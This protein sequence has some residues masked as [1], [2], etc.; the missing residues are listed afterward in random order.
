MKPTLILTALCYLTGVSP[1]LADV[2]TLKDGSSL[3]ARIITETAGA[4]LLD[5][6]VS[7][8]IKDERTVAKADVVSVRKVQ[9][10]FKA[11]QAVASLVPTPDLVTAADCLGRITQIEKF[12][13]DYTTSSSTKEAQELLATLQKEAAA[14]SA[15]SIKMAGKLVTT[16]EYEANAYELDAQIEEIKIRKSVAAGE[17]L[18][19]LR[20]FSNFDAEY[21][22]TSSHG[23]LLSLIRQVIQNQISEAKQSLLT[24]PERIKGRELGLLRMEPSDRA[25]SQAAIQEEAAQLEARYKAESSSKVKWLTMNPFHKASLEDTAKLGEAELVRLATVKA[26]LGTDGGKSY[27]EVYQAVHNGEANEMVTAAVTRAKTAMVP[28]RYLTPLETMAK[29]R[30]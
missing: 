5:V 21:A 17:F 15:G 8:G 7:K 13:K 29:G 25:G 2:F 16:A 9:P 23:A 1:C 28:V 22:T 4:Y 3:D 12:L 6:Q 10:D 14:I 19:A 30:K 26:A 18:V 11:F 27:R 20:L 24:L